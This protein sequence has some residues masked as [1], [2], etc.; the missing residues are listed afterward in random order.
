MSCEG[1]LL[2]GVRVTRVQGLQVPPAMELLSLECEHVW[3]EARRDSVGGKALTEHAT[4][5]AVVT[6]DDHASSAWRCSC[7]SAEI[8]H[9]R[10]RERSESSVRQHSRFL[11]STARLQCGSILVFLQGPGVGGAEED[12]R[13]PERGERLGRTAQVHRALVPRPRR[14]QSGVRPRGEG[15]HV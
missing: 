1:V 6:S 9:W 8:A 7:S 14:R 4:S 12:V 11:A 2:R 13:L 15:H 3:K 10:S 5:I